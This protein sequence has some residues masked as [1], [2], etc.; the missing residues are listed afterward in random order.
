MQLGY[1]VD[2]AATPLTTYQAA[3]WDR[4]RSYFIVFFEGTTSFQRSFDTEEVEA[5]CFVPCQ[6]VLDGLLR[7][8]LFSNITVEE[9][10]SRSRAYPKLRGAILNSDGEIVSCDFSLEEI[11]GDGG[12][13]SG[14][15]GLGMAH[16][17]ALEAWYQNKQ[18]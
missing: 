2:I 12:E 4:N 15:G 9:Q 14:K 5:V 13:G 10:I 8:T 7:P 1:N 16:R 3:L 17:F 18:K 11:V 6:V